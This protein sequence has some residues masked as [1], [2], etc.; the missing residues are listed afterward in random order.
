MNWHEIVWPPGCM[1]EYSCAT[2][3]VPT[4]SMTKYTHLMKSVLSHVFTQLHWFIPYSKALGSHWI[5]S[6]ILFL[7][8]NILGRFFGIHVSSKASHVLT[9][10]L[11][12]YLIYEYPTLASTHKP[13]KLSPMRDPSGA[14]KVL[15]NRGC[16]RTSSRSWR[17]VFIK[18][19]LILFQVA[20]I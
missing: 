19:P 14:R 15:Q 4:I 13:S 10:K 11:H 1:H 17:M 9:V 3:K 5:L 8:P 2:M 7:A 18:L 12:I 16:L 20:M 6:M